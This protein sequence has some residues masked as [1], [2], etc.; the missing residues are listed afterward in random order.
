[1]SV[2]KFPFEIFICAVVLFKLLVEQLG[3][4]QSVE[5]LGCILGTWA[6]IFNVPR[7]GGNDSS[8]AASQGVL[9][10]PRVPRWALDYLIQLNTCLCSPPES[11][12]QSL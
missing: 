4:A 9:G 10:E 11:I 12:F 6:L 3:G 2:G 7:A 8:A 1:M 5:W